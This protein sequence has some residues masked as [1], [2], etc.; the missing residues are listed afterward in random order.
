MRLFGDNIKIP[1][2]I[3]IEMTIKLQDPLLV[4]SINI[5]M[6]ED[7]V[8]LKVTALFLL[9]LY[10]ANGDNWVSLGKTLS[11]LETMLQIIRNHLF[12]T[13]IHHIPINQYLV[14]TAGLCKKGHRCLQREISPSEKH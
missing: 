7:S 11:S 3:N 5:Y 2:L 4:Q 14:N 9:L 12:G 1:S 10:V 8:Q 6:I 13:K